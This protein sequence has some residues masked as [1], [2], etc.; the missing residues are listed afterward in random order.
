M[1][2]TRLCPPGSAA[3]PTADPA[4]LADRWEAATLPKQVENL[5][6][7]LRAA[8]GVHFKVI[9]DRLLTLSG[10]LIQ[11]IDPLDALLQVI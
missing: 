9:D 3:D 11:T 6:L 8:A 7:S 2:S 10:E 4:A 1:L 5:F